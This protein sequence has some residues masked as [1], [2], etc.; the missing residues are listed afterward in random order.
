MIKEN[1]KYTNEETIFYENVVHIIPKLFSR[2]INFA[3]KLIILK[4]PA[5]SSKKGNESM[6][7]Y[8][9]EY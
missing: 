3:A 8:K 9:Q 4:P 1:K 7:K 2:V 5:N 6:R